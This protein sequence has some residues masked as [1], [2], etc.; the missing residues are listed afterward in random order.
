MKTVLENADKIYVVDEK[1]KGLL[2]LL[3]L[4]KGRT[5]AKEVR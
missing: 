3:D 2:P 1:V 5:P 4:T